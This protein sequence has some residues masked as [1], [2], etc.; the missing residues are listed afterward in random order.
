MQYSTSTQHARNKD[1]A[2]STSAKQI[3]ED[4]H[5]PTKKSD[6]GSAAWVASTLE[7]PP[8]HQQHKSIHEVHIRKRAKVVL[9]SPPCAGAQR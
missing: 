5:H 6:T 9:I 7:R 2:E 4:H 1:R 3:Q 8:T